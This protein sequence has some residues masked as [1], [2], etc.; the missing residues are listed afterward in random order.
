MILCSFSLHLSWITEN[1][2]FEAQLTAKG[3]HLTKYV[4]VTKCNVVAKD[5]ARKAGVSIA[6]VSA[7]LNGTKNVS[8]KLQK[9]VY[10]AVDAVGYTPNMAAQSLK[11]GTSHIIGLILPDITNPFFAV[12]ARAVETAASAQKYTVLLCN[13]DED[14][15]KEKDF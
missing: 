9:R 1:T 15:S 8:E 14:S 2:N 5:V 13:S 3:H 4:A 7:T 6:T 10:A 12:L 11:T